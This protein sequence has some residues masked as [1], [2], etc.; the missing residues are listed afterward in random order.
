MCPLRPRKMHEFLPSQ[1]AGIWASWVLL[2]LPL[3]LTEFS[4]VSG[5]CLGVH[6]RPNSRMCLWGSPQIPCTALCPT[7][8]PNMHGWFSTARFYP[9]VQDW[10][11]ILAWN[12]SLVRGFFVFLGGF[13]VRLF[14][15]YWLSLLVKPVGWRVSE[16]VW[17]T[18]SMPW[19][20]LLYGHISREEN[21]S[22][23]LALEGGERL[24]P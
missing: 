23:F 1:I 12:L 3:L 18:C 6:V 7:A 16:L 14:V 4:R 24:V 8:G 15:L 19:G 17:S 2:A 20:E 11:L 10:S 21:F 22:P 5:T 9:V 13:I